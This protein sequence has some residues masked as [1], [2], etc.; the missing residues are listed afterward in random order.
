[1]RDNT[2]GVA[3]RFIAGVARPSHVAASFCWSFVW[4]IV[5]LV[6]L[7]LVG[8]RV[9]RIWADGREY[10]TFCNTLVELI[11]EPRDVAA[12]TFLRVMHF[13]TYFYFH[14]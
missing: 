8:F 5:F 14:Y 9:I 1:M 11:R 2:L 4:I 6:A 3:Y 10:D 12:F 13:S 7:H